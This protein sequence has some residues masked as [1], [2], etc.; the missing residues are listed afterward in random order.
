MFV[1]VGAM[2]RVLFGL[3]ILL[4]AMN[5]VTAKY[6]P[7]SVKLLFFKYNHTNSLWEVRFIELHRKRNKPN[8]L[9]RML[10]RLTIP[11]SQKN[12]YSK[13]NLLPLS[14]LTFGLGKLMLK[15]VCRVLLKNFNVSTQISRVFKK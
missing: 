9:T 12:K 11:I 10:R 1:T 5:S 6:E 3:L 15:N 14:N 2:F 4:F 13:A 7:N 8:V